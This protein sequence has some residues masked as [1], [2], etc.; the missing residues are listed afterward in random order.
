MWRSSTMTVG[1]P[2]GTSRGRLP[3]GAGLGCTLTSLLGTSALGTTSPGTA[4][5]WPFTCDSSLVSSATPVPLLS[6]PEVPEAEAECEHCPEYARQHHH[7][8][9]VVPILRMVGLDEDVAHP[10]DVGGRGVEV[11]HVGHPLR[12]VCGADDLVLDR[13]EDTRG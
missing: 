1:V 8:R 6:S 10:L 2:V 3:A 4:G 9:G 11:H 7:H 5:S 13:E 12:E